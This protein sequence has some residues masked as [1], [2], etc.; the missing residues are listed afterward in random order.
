MAADAVRIHAL[1]EAD[2]EQAA[3]HVH[4]GLPGLV[5][6]YKGRVVAPRDHGVALLQQLHAAHVARVDALGVVKLLHQLNRFLFL[7]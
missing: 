6:L 5:V 2:A 1:L 3:L 4:D 7:V